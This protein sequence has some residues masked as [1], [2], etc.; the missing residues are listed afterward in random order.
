MPRDHNRRRFVKGIAGAG[1]IGLSGCVG[2]L[3]GQGGGYPEETITLKIPFGKGGQTDLE[4]RLIADFLQEELGVSIVATNEP[5]AG[6]AVNYQQFQNADPDG[7]TISSFFYPVIATH[8]KVI[9]DFDYDPDA[10]TLLAQYSQVPF[11]IMTSYDSDL[12]RFPDLVELAKQRPIKMGFTGPV[13]P[14]AIP[15]LQIRD[16]VSDLTIEPLFVGGGG[17]LANAAQSGRVDAAANTFDTTAN[18]FAAQRTKPLV[19]LSEPNQELIDYYADTQGITITQDMFVTEYRDLIQDP[20]LMTVM[21]G[22]MG[23]PGLP[24]D[25]QDVLV[26]ALNSSMSEGTGWYQQMRDM[27]SHPNPTYGEELQSKWD[28]YKSQFEPYI[29][30]LKEFA[31]NHG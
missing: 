31:S 13:A 16:Q 29:P 7:Y 4:S 30:L 14:V 28:E 5:A 23:P 8:P 11:C 26:N 3:P 6:G 18:N 17:A 24:Q 12:E 21:K 27:G 1:L 20:P 10:F 15:M 25:K 9:P 22:M 2:S 19:I